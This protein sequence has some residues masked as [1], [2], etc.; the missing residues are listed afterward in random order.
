MLNEL[1]RSNKE[2]DDYSLLAEKINKVVNK[3]RIAYI[4]INVIIKELKAT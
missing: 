1:E 3:L 2:L 4:D